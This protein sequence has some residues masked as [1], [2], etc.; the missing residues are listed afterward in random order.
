[1]TE[2]IIQ[3]I[4][5]AVSTVGFGILFRLRARYMPV[6]FALGGACFAIYYLFAS[7]L[8]LDSFVA[9][10]M[11]TLFVTVISEVLARAKH[12]P[13]VI[14]ILT[15]LIPIVPGSSLYYMMRSFMTKNVDAALAHGAE[16][17]KIALGVAGGIIAVSVIGSL[18]NALI[19]R[20]KKGK[21]EQEE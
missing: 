8:K 18:A 10:L 1:M 11:A 9:A 5:A 20:I 16:A 2:F 19:E 14:F 4:M 15:S 21:A 12:S 6:V 17:L 13:A 3:L 7:V